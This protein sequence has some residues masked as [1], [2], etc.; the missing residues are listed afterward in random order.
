[1]VMADKGLVSFFRVTKCGLYS[2][3]DKGSAAE[4]IEGDLADSMKRV[5]DWLNGRE[6]KQ[7]IPWDIAD[8]PN[9]K[10]YYCKST[11]FNPATGDYLFVFWQ[12]LGDENGDVSGII[13]DST[14]GDQ[15]DDSIKVEHDAGGKEVIYGMPLYYWFIPEHNV[16]A[17]INFPHSSAATKEVLLYLKKCLDLRVDHPRKVIKEST[18]ENPETGRVIVNKSVSYRSEGDEYAMYYSLEAK[19]KELSLAQSDTKQ[20]A[21]DITHLVVRDRV[22]TIPEDTRHPLFKLWEKL[23]GDGEEK[24]VFSKDVELISEAVDLT[25]EELERFL[26]VYSNEMDSNGWSDIGFKTGV[27]TSTKW[28][29]SYIDR[30]HLSLDPAQMNRTYYAAKTLLEKIGRERDDLLKS[31]MRFKDGEEIDLKESISG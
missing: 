23:A 9:R 29:G 26:H 30:T 5:F 18:K 7:T 19:I 10:Q 14:V 11:C 31:V 2:R 6:F 13:A 25:P 15:A 1:M 20:L 28:F 4:H 16:I 27:N 22:S 12:R 24:S 8:V 3:A 21:S 17:T